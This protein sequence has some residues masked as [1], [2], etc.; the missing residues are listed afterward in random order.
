[1]DVF[2]F[3]PDKLTSNM[4]RGDVSQGCTTILKKKKKGQGLHLRTVPPVEAP[5]CTLACLCKHPS[6]S[7]GEHISTFSLP[8][9][10]SIWGPCEAK[11]PFPALFLGVGQQTGRR[12]QYRFV[13]QLQCLQVCGSPAN[14]HSPVITQ[15]QALPCSLGHWVFLSTILFSD[16]WQLLAD[17]FRSL[18][19]LKETVV[20]VQRRP[21]VS[22]QVSR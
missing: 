14:S 13:D 19:N 4:F 2:D 16:V 1:M 20:A 11:H 9:E 5:S 21:E 18:I 7:F 17:H 15:T 8:L 22:L 3:S 12:F 6:S 10:T